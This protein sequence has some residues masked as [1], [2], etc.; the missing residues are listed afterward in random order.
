MRSTVL[1]VMPFS[2]HGTI[3]EADVRKRLLTEY[4]NL[5]EMPLL[6]IYAA[7]V[8]DPFGDYYPIVEKK[9]GKIF[10][11]LSTERVRQYF[12]C[13]TRRIIA[14][15]QGLDAALEHKHEH[16]RTFFDDQAEFEN[17]ANFVEDAS[18][19]S[20]SN[21][22]VYDGY[23]QDF[24]SWLYSQLMAA[25]QKQESTISFVILQMFDEVST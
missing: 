1:V 4:S 16:G 11:Q 20:T 25:D 12:L 2:E 15:L 24:N 17:A 23:R 3:N 19:Y 21:L 22:Y 18:L 6:T 8:L 14:K 9:D 5:S 7:S 10:V 13:S